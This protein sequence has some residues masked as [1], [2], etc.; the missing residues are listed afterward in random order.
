MYPQSCG[1]D[2]IQDSFNIYT[3]K[4]CLWFSNLNCNGDMWQNFIVIASRFK[5]L[6]IVY[7]QNSKAVNYQ[8]LYITLQDFDPELKNHLS[9]FKNVFDKKRIWNHKIE[10]TYFEVVKRIFLLIPIHYT[11][12]T[13]IKIL[14]LIY[15]K[16]CYI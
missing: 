8:L 13:Y 9:C 3:I 2:L 6:S 10:Y 11:E 1:S 5:T 15:N 12:V 16:I 7:L 14:R 4:M